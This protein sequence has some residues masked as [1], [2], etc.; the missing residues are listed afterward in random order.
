VGLD[1]NYVRTQGSYK[2]ILYQT[3]KRAKY[4]GCEKIDLAYTAGMEK[5]KVGAK[6]KNNFGFAMALEHDSYAE[7]QSLK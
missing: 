6:P 1:Y 5:K 3:V 7:M 2:Q 4:L